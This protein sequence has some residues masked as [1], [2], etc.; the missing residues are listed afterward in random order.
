MMILER[1][2]LP[3]LQQIEAQG[4]Y[5]DARMLHSYLGENVNLPELANII[6]FQDPGP[7]ADRPISGNPRPE[8][9]S[10][11]APFTHRTYERVNRPGATRHGRDAALMQTLLGGKAQGAEMAALS[12]DR[13]MT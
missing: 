10:T 6:K 8:Y 2:T 13:S 4:G 7:E 3:L 9:V 12:M 5:V 11:K 1:V